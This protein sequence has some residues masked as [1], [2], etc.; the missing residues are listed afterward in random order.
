MKSSGV[1][2]VVPTGTTLGKDISVSRGANHLLKQLDQNATRLV[3]HYVMR[4]RRGDY[5][6][7]DPTEHLLNVRRLHLGEGRIVSHYDTPK[8]TLL[9][10]TIL[11]RTAN[12]RTLLLTPDEDA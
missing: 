3:L 1:E 5:G 10:A 4:Q 8:G 11:S 9:V 12:P 7:A 6:N 2:T